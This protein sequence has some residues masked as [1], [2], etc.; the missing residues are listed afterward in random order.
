MLSMDNEIAT[1]RYC[2]QDGYTIIRELL[3][4]KCCD[5][6]LSKS[7]QHQASIIYNKIYRL[8]SGRVKIV[9]STDDNNSR[10]GSI[11]C[12]DHHCNK[13][14][15]C[16]DEVGSESPPIIEQFRSNQLIP[17]DIINKLRRVEYSNVDT[18]QVSLVTNLRSVQYKFDMTFKHWIYIQLSKYENGRVTDDIDTYNH[19]IHLTQTSDNIIESYQSKI[20]AS[21]Q[22]ADNHIMTLPFQT[23]DKSMA[24]ACNGLDYFDRTR[25]E[26]FIEATI[27]QSIGNYN[28]VIN[29][30]TMNRLMPYSKLND[31]LVNLALN[32]YVLIFRLLF[33]LVISYCI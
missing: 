10:T 4:K 28:I 29:Q 25:D 3:S 19:F 7:I 30:S 14:Q 16:V 26:T 33:L 31:E 13:F 23:V 11:L 15:V 6:K 27:L 18:H 8:Y 9:T 2:G 1:K 17:F 20:S 24:M 32:W 5:K 12:Y 22:Q 21:S